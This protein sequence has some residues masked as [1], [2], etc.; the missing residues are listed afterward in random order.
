LSNLKVPNSH[1]IT[2]IHEF[3]PQGILGV[4]W[5]PKVFALTALGSE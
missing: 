2:A 3:H 1:P 5:L 4:S